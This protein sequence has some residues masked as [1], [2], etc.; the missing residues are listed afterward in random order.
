MLLILLARARSLDIIVTLL[1]WIAQRFVSSKRPI[2]YDFSGFLKSK[3][4]RALESKF[5]LEFMN[6]F[7]YKPLGRKLSKEDIII[8]FMFFNFSKIF[9]VLFVI[10][11]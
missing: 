8:F 11:I 5:L 10:S 1:A 3:N 2:K 7:C 6:D 9:I 4:I